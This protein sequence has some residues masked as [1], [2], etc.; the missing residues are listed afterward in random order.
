MF[1]DGFRSSIEAKLEDQTISKIAEKIWV[2][3]VYFYWNL[4]IIGI[5]IE[6]FK[7]GEHLGVN[8]QNDI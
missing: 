5:D 4:R 1:G 2:V 7:E 6:N 3:Q 8:T